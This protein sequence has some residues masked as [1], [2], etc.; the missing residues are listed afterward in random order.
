MKLFSSGSSLY[1]THAF[2]PLRFLLKIQQNSP[3]DCTS[4]FNILLLF[5]QSEDIKSS[6]LFSVLSFFL[7]FLDLVYSYICFHSFSFT[8]R[9][10]RS[11]SATIPSIQIF[12]L[13]CSQAHQ[14]PFRLS[15]VPPLLLLVPR[16]L[17]CATGGEAAVDPLMAPGRES[18]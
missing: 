13:P 18:E 12:S 16:V 14:P 15:P 1:H 11:P 7:S 4:F 6:F 17:I 8:S 5:F 3:K 9:I 10:S 2:S